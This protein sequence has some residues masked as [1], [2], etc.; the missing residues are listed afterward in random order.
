M[1]TDYQQQKESQKEIRKITRR[2]Q[3]IEDQLTLMEAREVEINQAMISTNDANQL[4]D[5]QKELDQLSQ[6]QEEL[7]EE[8]EDLSQGLE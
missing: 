7:M 5:L 4:M 2:I 6:E 1:T 3:Q 8:W